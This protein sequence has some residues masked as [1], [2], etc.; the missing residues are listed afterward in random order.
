MQAIERALW[1]I[2][3]H[4]GE[5][6]VLAD[7]ARVSGLSRFHLARTFAVIVGQPVLTFARA[8]RLS[9][10]ARLLADGA[11][12]ILQVA[13][14]VGY[15]SHEAFTRAFR[16]RFGMTPED[17][18]TRRSLSSLSITEPL[19]MPDQ[20][21]NQISP[22]R[23]VSG[24]TMLFAGLRR[25]FRFEER[26]GIASLWQAFG[27]HLGAITNTIPGAAFGLCLA[28]ADPGD[29]TGFDYA[30]AVE[31]STLSDLT[32]GLS[33]IRIAPREWAVFRHA[34]HVSSLGG[35]C[36]AAGEWL[37][38]SGRQPADCALQMIE[39][40]GPEFNSHSGDGGCEVWIP[41]APSI[42]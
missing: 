21:A 18:R 40:Y 13:L 11:P 37:A 7:V 36:A 38:V 16:E 2:E 3:S 33:G 39:R 27:P 20:S 22:D 4:L 15:G 1:Y 34:G 23:F 29:E 5:P 42:A 26:A 35:T 41:V 25:Y 24:K 9:E 32:E 12:D 19:R 10:A 14:T 30:P 31:V 6:I 28:P 17:L 8:R